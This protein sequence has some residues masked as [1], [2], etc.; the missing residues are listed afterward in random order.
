MTLRRHYLPNE[1]DETENLERMLSHE[2]DYHPRPQ[3]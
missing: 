1:N 2:P 3:W